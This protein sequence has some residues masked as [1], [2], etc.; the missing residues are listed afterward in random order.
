MNRDDDLAA[1]LAST[2]VQPVPPGQELHR[3]SAKV[4]E[5]GHLVW[6]LLAANPG[7]LS[8]DDLVELTELSQSQIARAFQYIRDEWAGE[9]EQP[10]I[11]QPGK[12]NVYKLN[13]VAV[14]SRDDVRRRIHTWGVQIRRV[15]TAIVHPSVAKFGDDPGFRALNRH[16]QMVE[17]DLADLMR[18]AFDGAAA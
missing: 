18:R 8:M 7:G 15:R 9:Q 14:E 2:Q 3:Y 1:L 17:E 5:H 4:I 16:M 10:I 12:R 6:D 11:Y 13:T